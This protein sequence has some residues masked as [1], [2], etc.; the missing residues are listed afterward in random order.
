MHYAGKMCDM[1]LISKIAK[2]YNLKI[3][4][5]CAQSYYAKLN[6]R[7]A[8]SFSNAASFSMNPMKPF[9]GIGEAG[10]IT[11]NDY[12][13]YLFLKKLRHAGTSSDPKRKITNI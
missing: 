2:K 9:G 7:N 6:G 5:D 1:F 13:T 4:E 11:T 12:K 10:L 8:G 3:I